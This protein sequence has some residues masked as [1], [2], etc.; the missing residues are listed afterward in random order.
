VANQGQVSSDSGT[1]LTDDPDT[2][3]AGDPT[4]TPVIQQIEADVSVAKGGP[5]QVTV[6]GTI[7]YTLMVS[8]SGPDEA[9]NVVVTDTLPA[10]VTFVSASPE[11]SEAAGIVTCVLPS[12]A[13]SATVNLAIDVTAPNTPGTLTNSVTVDSGATDDPPG[14]N[15]DAFNTTVV[16][17]DLS[18]LKVDNPDP[19]QV[20]SNLTYTVTVTNNGAGN[21]TGVTMTDT[22]P[23]GVSF[24]SA[25]PSQ[26]SCTGTSTVTCNLGSLAASANATVTLVV[27][28]TAAGT[29]TNTVSVDGIG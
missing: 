13:A 6:G 4:V 22:L 11:C 12:V 24:V 29:I 21:A 20:G 25:T 7:M 28:P 3:A 9:P 10:G 17:P 1:V 18:I 16:E 5:T 2:P 15:S 14:N 19:V 26:G 23:P 27:T 8:N